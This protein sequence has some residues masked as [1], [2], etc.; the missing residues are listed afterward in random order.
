[1]KQQSRHYINQYL[2]QAN[3]SHHADLK[4]LTPEER[5]D[6]LNTLR[7][8]E[9]L[10]LPASQNNCEGMNGTM[11]AMESRD[12]AEFRDALEEL[13]RAV[14]QMDGQQRGQ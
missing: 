11:A 7:E 3:N 4:L 2:N 8:L 5:T 10:V 1:M 6:A 9:K 14:S 12:V 13:S